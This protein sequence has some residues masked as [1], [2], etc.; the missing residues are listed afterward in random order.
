MANA[1]HIVSFQTANQ[2][3]EAGYPQPE[4]MQGQFWYGVFGRLSMVM[5]YDASFAFLYS[6]GN[7][8]IIRQSIDDFCSF[9]E[10]APCAT[11]IMEQPEMCHHDITFLNTWSVGDLNEPVEHSTRNDNPAEAAAL[12]YLKV[13][14][15]G[16]METKS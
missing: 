16:T 14:A 12:E 11:E 5:D 2:L 1:N 7:K 13:K 10:Y 15:N 6:F 3:K 9:L 4:L 8:Q